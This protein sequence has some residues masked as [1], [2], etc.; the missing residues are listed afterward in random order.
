MS[1]AKL[2]RI[3]VAMLA[4]LAFAPASIAVAG[5]T[6]ST[7]YPPVD[8]LEVTVTNP[9]GL[10]GYPVNVVITGCV[11]GERVIVTLGD[12]TI[13]AT[14]DGTTIQVVL[15]IGAPDEPGVYDVVV[16]FPDRDEPTSRTI[17]ITVLSP[18]QPTTT[19]PTGVSPATSAPNA[20]LPSTGSDGVFGMAWLAAVVLVGGIGLVVVARRRSDRS[21]QS[22]A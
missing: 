22:P 4:V 11:P 13:E 19:V 2:V 20:N 9:E 10:P 12:E 7:A 14:C 17:P 18:G 1:T 8:E 6:P 21:G 15:D 16:T 5:P 3:C